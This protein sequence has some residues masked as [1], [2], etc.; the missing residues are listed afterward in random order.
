MQRKTQSLAYKVQQ[1]TGWPAQFLLPLSLKAKVD[2]PQEG[3]QVCSHLRKPI[4]QINQ[5]STDQAVFSKVDDPQSLASPS[6]QSTRCCTMFYTC[7]FMLLV[8][9]S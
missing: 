3:K 5:T 1:S 2:L 9:V 4:R 8:D 6:C 7:L